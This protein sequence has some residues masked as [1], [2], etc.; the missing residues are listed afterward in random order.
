MALTEGAKQFVLAPDFIVT[1]LA[2]PHIPICP[3][4]THRPA[5]GAASP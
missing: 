1:W 3:P 4:A 5:P 2:E